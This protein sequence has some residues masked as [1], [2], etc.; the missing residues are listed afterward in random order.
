LLALLDQAR[1]QHLGV[2]VK[3]TTAGL[4]SRHR[5]LLSATAGELAR[6]K[7]RRRVFPAPGG[8][9]CTACGSRE[10]TG[11]RPQGSTT[12]GPPGSAERFRPL[13]RIFLRRGEAA[14]H[15]SSRMRAWVSAASR[16]KRHCPSWGTNAS[17]YMSYAKRSDARSATPVAT[18]PP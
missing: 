6:D 5:V 1:P 17:R 13:K 8:W 12:S 11:G 10:R 9:A 18:I 3:P 15:D 4:P 16:S 14:L 7:R 2:P